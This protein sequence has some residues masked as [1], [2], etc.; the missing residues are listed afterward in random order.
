MLE[1]YIVFKGHLCT[2]LPKFHCELNEPDLFWAVGKD[3][4]K[5]TNTFESRTHIPRL[6]AAFESITMA[7]SRHIFCKIRDYETAYREGGCTTTNVE[8]YVAQMKKDRLA[9]RHIHASQELLAMSH[10]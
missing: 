9:H 7:Q 8:K 10:T 2:F 4:F 3:T 1:D 6:E 5:R